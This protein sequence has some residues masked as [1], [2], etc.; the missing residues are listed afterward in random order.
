MHWHCSHLWL[1]LEILKLC[2]LLVRRYDRDPEVALS[3]SPYPVSEQWYISWP[4]ARR[5]LQPFIQCLPSCGGHHQAYAV[6]LQS[7]SLLDLHQ[8]QLEVHV[9]RGDLSE[10]L[11]LQSRLFVRRRHHWDSFVG[12]DLDFAIESEGC[13]LIMFRVDELPRR[14][15][16]MLHHDVWLDLHEDSDLRGVSCVLGHVGHLLREKPGFSLADLL[17][18]DPDEDRKQD[19]FLVL[20]EGI[21]D[22]HLFYRVTDSDQ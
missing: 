14:V 15:A 21:G 9:P 18:S 8:C 6:G 7:S 13:S 10:F 5:P 20:G 4:E 1:A 11:P 3:V 12:R 22:E 17:P 19:V 2:G 16:T